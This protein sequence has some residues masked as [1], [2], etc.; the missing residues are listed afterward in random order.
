MLL[1]IIRFGFFYLLTIIM[2]TTVSG[3]NCIEHGVDDGN[4]IV[5][6][7]GARIGQTFMPCK[8]GKIST[9]YL[10]FGTAGTYNLYVGTPVKGLLPSIYQT[11]SVTNI[12]PIPTV[13]NLHSPFPVIAN[14]TYEIQIVHIK[15]GFVMRAHTPPDYPNGE[16]T[17]DG[18]V[19]LG[20][21]DLDFGIEILPQSIQNIIPTF[22]QWGL[23]I[24]TLLIM[25]M[26]IHFILRRVKINMKI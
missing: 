8:S 25:N 2:I 14:M 23:F 26:S 9:L 21:F 20:N 11:F 4:T 16:S 1:G 12:S 7:S 22:S 10:T 24:F 17:F 6:S 5:G 13:I 15:T 18:G 19:P 3:Q